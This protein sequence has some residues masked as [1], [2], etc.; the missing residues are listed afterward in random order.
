LRDVIYKRI[1]KYND[2]LLKFIKKSIKRVPYFMNL[3]EECLADIIY[4]LVTEKYAKHE[5][6]QEPGG[7]ANH[8]LFLQ[9]GIIEISTSF[10][11]QEFVIERLF[12]GSIVNFRTFFQ[13][14]GAVVT[15]KFS[16]T[17]V[18]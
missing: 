17:S 18:V 1:Y 15:L 5:I 7:D 11:G 10:E 2:R 9:S 12:R 6:L 13:V 3:E 4:A 14:E 8:L 16:K